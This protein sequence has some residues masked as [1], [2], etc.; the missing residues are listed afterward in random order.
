MKKKEPKICQI[1]DNK[2]KPVQKKVSNKFKYAI[3][4]I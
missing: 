1:L 4:R 3:L 2:T